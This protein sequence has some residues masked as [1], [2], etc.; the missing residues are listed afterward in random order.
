MRVVFLL[1]FLV[2]IILNQLSEYLFRENEILKAKIL[3]SISNLIDSKDFILGAGLLEFEDS[4]ARYN[5]TQ[6]AVGT[7]SGTSALKIALKALDLKKDDEVIVPAH[8]FIS[9]ALA[10]LDVGAKLILCDIDQQTFNLDPK[11][12]VK[13]ITKKTKAIIP[14]HLYGQMANLENIRNI[15]G[16]HIPIIE[17]ASQAHGA[18]RMI[19][20]RQ[21]KA[22]SF[23]EFG[24]FSFYPTKNLGAIGDAGCILTHKRD[25]YEKLKALRNYGQFHKNSHEIIGGNERLDTIQA[26]ILTEKLK[27]LDELNLKRRIVADWYFDILDN[28]KLSLPFIDLSN[29]HV[30]HQFVI[31]IKNRDKI[32]Q[33]LLDSGVNCGIHYPTPIHLHLCFK[34]LQYKI[35]D[36]PIAESICKEILS[37][38]MSP[39]LSKNEIDFIGSKLKKITQNF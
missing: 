15:V 38:P 18:T 25:V 12:L 7:S 31:R 4:F 39:Y 19:E 9:T 6:Y 32:F 36:F 26:I 29:T 23:G 11:L 35:G 33:E 16:D 14:V 20:G 2:G 17:D 3:N 5:N 30:F 28:L 27:L 8:T 21:I 13:L 22:G 1:I 24:C 10:V 37:L 34:D